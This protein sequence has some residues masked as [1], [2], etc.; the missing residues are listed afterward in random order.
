MGS[1]PVSEKESSPAFGFGNSPRS[2]REYIGRVPGPGTY[3]T[4]KSLGPQSESIRPSST[5]TVFG[6]ST[7]DDIQKVNFLTYTSS[8]LTSRDRSTWIKP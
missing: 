2:A 3:K 1:Q 5:K 8:L 4:S 7:R 6:S